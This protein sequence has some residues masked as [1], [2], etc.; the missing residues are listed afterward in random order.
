M[1]EKDEILATVGFSHPSLEAL[2][3]LAA[4]IDPHAPPSPK[5]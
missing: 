4:P 5:L 3:N 2:C 1:Q